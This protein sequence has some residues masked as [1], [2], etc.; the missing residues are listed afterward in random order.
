MAKAAG[1]C[2][3]S[4]TCR[5]ASIHSSQV[6]SAPGIATP[7]CSKRVR[8]RSRREGELRQE[9]GIASDPSSRIQSRRSPK[10]SSQ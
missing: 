3:L 7:A 1:S 9:A 10:F 5:L 2:W 8:W 6:A 4:I